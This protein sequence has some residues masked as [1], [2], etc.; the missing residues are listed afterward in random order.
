MKHGILQGSLPLQRNW[1]IPA[2]GSWLITPLEFRTSFPFE[3]S[4]VSRSMD[5][6]GLFAN[7]WAET[8]TQV[9]IFNG[10]EQQRPA[11]RAL[12]L[13]QCVHNKR[14]SKCW[15][16]EHVFYAICPSVCVKSAKQC[17][18]D[19]KVHDCNITGCIRLTCD[20]Q[21]NIREIKGSGEI[22]NTGLIFIAWSQGC[23]HTLAREK[24]ISMPR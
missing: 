10:A 6:S 7:C 16:N 8:T 1:T 18:P 3:V 20:F 4:S 14:V 23:T 12:I 19:Y 24:H 13:Q 22:K 21:K 2:D 17:L 15:E 9:K 11:I 5:K